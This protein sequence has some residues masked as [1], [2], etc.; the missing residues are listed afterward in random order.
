MP[1]GTAAAAD[2]RRE[3]ERWI[4]WPIGDR[5]KGGWIGIG[6]GDWP[7]LARQYGVLVGRIGGLKLVIYS[8]VSASEPVTTCALVEVNLHQATTDCCS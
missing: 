7:C 4:A 5:I 1:A 2:E 8:V 6:I 3:D